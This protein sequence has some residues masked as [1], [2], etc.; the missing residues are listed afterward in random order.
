MNRKRHN[1]LHQIYRRIPAIKCK[2]L[3]YGSCTVLGMTK[4]EADNMTRAGGKPPTVREDGSCVYLEN[5]RCSIYNERPGI[6]RVWGAA[7]KL[8]CPFG[9]PPVETFTEHDSEA[10]L[11]LLEK[12]FGE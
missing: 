11:R 8:A 6:C 9:C 10:V 12:E 3:C 5:K 1:K 7:P 2:G 4:G